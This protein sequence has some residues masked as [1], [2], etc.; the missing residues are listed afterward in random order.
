MSPEVSIVLPTFNRLQYLRPAVDS[1][2][3]LY[4]LGTH[5]RR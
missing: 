4:R 1:V 3:D 2:F 5:R